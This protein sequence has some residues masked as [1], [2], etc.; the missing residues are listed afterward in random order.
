M[1]RLLRVSP[2]EL[3]AGVFRRD[4]HDVERLNWITLKDKDSKGL[5]SCGN[6]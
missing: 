2:E 5:E 6:R 1:L 3:K 4:R